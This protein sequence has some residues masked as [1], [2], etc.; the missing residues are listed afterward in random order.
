M[1]KKLYC[2]DVL[3]SRRPDGSRTGALN[4]LPDRH[5]ESGVRI[6]K[7]AGRSRL[8]NP[9]RHAAVRAVAA[10]AMAAGVVADAGVRAQVPD[11]GPP[12]GRL[13][14]IGG[15]RLHLHCTGSGSPTV[16]IEAGASAF[17][18]DF[19]LVQPEVAKTTRVCAYDRAGSGWSERRPDVDTPIRVI[20]DLS[21][22][23]DAVGENGPFV[24]V[25][26]SRGGAFVRLFQ[27]VHPGRVAGLVLVD[28]T[29][30]DQLFVMFE[31]RAVALTSLT[32]EQHSA[33]LP[34][35]EASI[36]IPTR[37]PQT[38]APFDRLPP[39]LY[40]TRVALDRRLIASMPPTVSGGI[41]VESARGDFAMLTRLS[42]ARKAT[43]NVLGDLPLI[44]LTRGL[45]SSPAQQAAHADISRLS[46][47]SRHQV[48][49]DSY[50]EIHLSHPEA[51]V[52]AVTDVVNAV[53]G[54]TPL[55]RP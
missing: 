36:P 24:M 34:T 28:P 17:A 30:E 1:K 23:L 31:G 43:P 10:A 29:A 21:A 26:A 25:G 46:R 42:S 50:H 40:E 54:G 53:R 8:R 7:P 41:V 38:G 20:E 48:V 52:A 3:E 15:R 18:L 47:N 13:V 19:A 55:R 37:P 33:T 9:W 11:V 6:L 49:A 5:V 16:V 51:V 12:P 2:P 44:V 14:D 35:P 45:G 32:P 4:L 39:P 27:A 22:L